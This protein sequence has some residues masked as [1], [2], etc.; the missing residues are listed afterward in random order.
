VPAGTV[1]FRPSDECAGFLALTRGAIKVSLTSASGRE[2][3]LYRVTPGDVCLQTFGCL[4]EGR[5]YSA[6]GVAETALEAELI[7]PPEF[8]RRMTSDPA[9]RAQVFASIARRFADFEH[10]VEAL[11]FTALAPRVARALLRLAG[12]RAEAVATHEQIAVEIGSAREAVSRQLAAFGRDGL[13][14]AGRGRIAL[15]DRAALQ[16]LADGAG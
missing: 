9:F 15:L 12:G 6:A 13:V 11:A 5:R 14:R 3:V 4:V 7:P 10:M 8:E 1:L 2:I 16:R